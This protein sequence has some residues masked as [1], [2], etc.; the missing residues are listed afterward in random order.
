MRI[1]YRMVVCIAQSRVA[2]VL[3]LRG[4]AYQV[5]SLQ[6]LPRGEVY[7]SPTPAHPDKESAIHT[8]HPQGIAQPVQD[9]T[10]HPPPTARALLK[11]A[12]PPFFWLCRRRCRSCRRSG[13]SNLFRRCRWYKLLFLNNFLRGQWE[14]CAGPCAAYNAHPGVSYRGDAQLSE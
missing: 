7:P 3:A 9:A 14:R 2:G 8:A 5:R 12:A 11:S 10:A 4:E 6:P 13:R 1:S